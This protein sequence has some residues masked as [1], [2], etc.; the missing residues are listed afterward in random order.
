MRGGLLYVLIPC[1]DSFLFVTSVAL[2]GVFIL[3]SLIV[4]WLISFFAY[5]VFLLFW[6]ASHMWSFCVLNLR[7]SGYEVIALFGLLVF[8][9]VSGDWILLVLVLVLLLS[10]LFH[11]S[12]Q[13]VLGHFGVLMWSC[14]WDVLSWYAVVAVSDAGVSLAI[15]V[16]VAVVG[17][18]LEI[19]VAGSRS[20]VLLSLAPLYFWPR[21]S[22]CVGGVS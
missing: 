20:G 10:S 15:L 5:R 6:L 1:S 17:F 12:R 2:T 9:H 7:S 4:R 19:A 3:S 14:C 11:L 21:L 18:V 22:K 13:I 8:R 16:I